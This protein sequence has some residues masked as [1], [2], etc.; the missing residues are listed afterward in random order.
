[1]IYDR[2]IRIARHCIVALF[3]I[4]SLFGAAS[5]ARGNWMDALCFLAWNINLCFVWYTMIVQQ[6][7]RN[8]AR[9]AQDGIR[10]LQELQEP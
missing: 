7:T 10:R 9:A 5:V 6:R 1:V 3:G 2:D 4:D 8:A